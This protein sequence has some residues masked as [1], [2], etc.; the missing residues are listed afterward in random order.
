[1]VA[2]D[3]A[4]HR[5]YES[6]REHTLCDNLEMVNKTKPELTWSGKE[7]R[8][9]LEPGEEVEMISKSLEHAAA[10]PFRSQYQYVP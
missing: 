8:P 7:N 3:K 10:P 4:M 2:I 1:M 6:T 9:R 5:L